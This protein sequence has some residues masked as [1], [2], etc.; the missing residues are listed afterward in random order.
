MSRDRDIGHH[1]SRYSV[2]PLTGEEFLY[3]SHPSTEGKPVCRKGYLHHF[4]FGLVEF[5]AALWFERLYAGQ[6]GGVSA[7]AL[8]KL[9]QSL[10]MLENFEAVR[11]IGFS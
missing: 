2:A 1:L 9:C 3:R 11:W 4:L 6:G 7:L 10:R 8:P 5:H